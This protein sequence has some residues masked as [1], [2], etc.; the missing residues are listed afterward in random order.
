MK[1]FVQGESRTQVIL[2]P[3][4]L[5]DYVVETNPVRVV[6]VFVD[7]LDLGKLGFDGVDPA[8]TGRPA[9]HPAVLLKIY[10]YGYLNR[11]QSSRRLESEAQRNV[12]LM[13]LTGRL[14][15]DFKTIANFRK[16]NGKAIRGVCRQF[17]VLCRQLGLLS[18]D[19]VAI[20][21]SK[22]KAVNNRDR[23]F[24]SAKLKRRMQEIEASID[25]YLAALDT[26]D[27]QE[28]SVAQ[29]KTER[30]QDKIAALKT[31]MQEL[32][33][34][35]VQLNATP[36]KQISLTDPDARS[37][38]TRGTGIVGYNAQ[39]AVDA[40]HHLI[41]AH[42]VTNDG[43][44]RSQL[45]SMAKQ[46]RSA[47]GGE[48]LTAVADRGYFKG[49]EILACEQAGITVIVPK[50]LT[51]GS[52]AEGRFGKQDFVYL[53]DDDE[54]R[55]PAGQRL[56]RHFAVVEH[57]MTLH[58]YWS[59]ACQGCAMRAQCTTSAE[60][61]RIKRWEH[62]AVLD[63][64]QARLDNA[65]EM[66]RIRRQTVEHP[67]GTIK[68]WMGAT[69]FLTKTL[70]RVS[71]EMSLHVLAYNMKRVIKL[72]GIGGLIDAIRAY[73]LYLLCVL[74]AYIDKATGGLGFN[75]SPA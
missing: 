31:R 71:T 13:W 63:A 40:K 1:R 26:A 29:V 23:N 15:P 32:K 39:I 70:P 58:A 11:I 41:V 54:Y 47:M 16:D 38:K 19:V 9:Y 49:E 21:G 46:A 65:P 12:E 20:D 75:E 57:G 2:L 72:L 34:I 67:F 50:P 22:F 33:A 30:L 4:C 7:E 25:R 35:E 51:S 44:D 8:A 28:S 36:D 64:M 24:T 55:C 17:V 52:K 14:M 69:H 48:E 45:S 43:I 60:P 73:A 68:S 5:D 62:E 61:R 66:M 18:A 37:M 27:R 3:E 59:S 10:L 74:R 56:T 53:A 42:E 6:D